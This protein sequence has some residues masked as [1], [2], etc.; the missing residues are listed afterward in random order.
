MEYQ[1]F[2][3]LPPEQEQSF[4][5]YERTSSESLKKAMTLGTISGVVVGVLALMLFFSYDAPP[6]IHAEPMPEDEI[7]EEAPAP[8][9]APA[10]TPAP[11]PE[12][13]AEEPAAE[14]EAAAAD[15]AAAPATEAPPPPKGATK[16]PP[17]A[18]IGQ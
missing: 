16:A 9:A 18:L 17:T 15:P 12:P 5:I 13:A 10:P 6:N 2:T 14:P 11:E 3:S 1:D 8:K 7:E 4:I